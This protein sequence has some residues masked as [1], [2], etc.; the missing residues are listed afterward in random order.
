MQSEKTS[1]FFYENIKLSNE[2]VIVEI[3]PVGLE[4]TKNEFPEKITIFLRFQILIVSLR[5]PSSQKTKQRV[6]CCSVSTSR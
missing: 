5:Q 6:F 2:S 4:K 3:Q 1:M